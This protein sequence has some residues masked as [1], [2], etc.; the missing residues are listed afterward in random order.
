MGIFASRPEEPFEWAGLPAEPAEP[1]SAVDRLDGAMIEAGG[2]G[3]ATIESIVVPIA[4]PIEIVG[5][6]DPDDSSDG[7]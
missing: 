1:E 5:T 3:G 4:M 6:N 2:L 7:D